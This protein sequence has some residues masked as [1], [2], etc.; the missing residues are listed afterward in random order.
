MLDAVIAQELLDVNDN[1]VVLYG[2]THSRHTLCVF[3]EN[4]KLIRVWSDHTGVLVRWEEF[5]QMHG[6][7]LFAN[8]KRWYENGT[9]PMLRDFVESFS[10]DRLPETPGGSVASRGAAFY[11]K[12]KDEERTIYITERKQQ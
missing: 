10:F 2:Y 1:E 4:G 11:A 5:E 12:P 8:V 7:V 6:D 9:L 3:F